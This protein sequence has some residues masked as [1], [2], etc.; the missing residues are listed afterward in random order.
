[1]GQSSHN[2]RLHSPFCSLS[3]LICMGLACE[4][5]YTGV[6]MSMSLSTARDLATDVLKGKIILTVAHDSERSI[7]PFDV[8]IK[9]TK[10][11]FVK[12]HVNIE[13]SG[14]SFASVFRGP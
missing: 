10:L 13:V 2:G 4:R 1:M 6:Y 5:L 14:P 8:S 11:Y 7:L 3:G 9:S 12:H